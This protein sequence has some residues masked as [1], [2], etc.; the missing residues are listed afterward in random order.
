ML[1]YCL[2]PLADTILLNYH[3]STSLTIYTR[4]VEIQ[5]IYTFWLKEIMMVLTETEPSTT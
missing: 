2:A 4:A 1:W 5:E 3:K